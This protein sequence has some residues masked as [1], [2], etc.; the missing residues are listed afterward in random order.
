MPDRAHLERVARQRPEPIFATNS[1]AH[2]Y[3]FASPDS[4]VGLRGAFLLPTRA[5]LGLHPSKETITIS[6]NSTIELDR[7]AHDI[8]KFARMMTTHNGYSVGTTSTAL[9]KG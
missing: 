1:G 4:D 3:G 9:S 6:D 2:L 8:R 7:V 5:I